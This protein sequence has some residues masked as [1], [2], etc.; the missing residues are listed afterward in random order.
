MTQRARRLFSQSSPSQV[1][2]SRF[3][4]THSNTYSCII[5]TWYSRRLQALKSAVVPSADRTRKGGGSD[6]N[7]NARDT[8][9]L[10]AEVVN[11]GSRLGVVFF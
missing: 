9:N 6:H 2:T 1:T 11:L 4:S 7:F 8:S 5:E 3:G 10:P